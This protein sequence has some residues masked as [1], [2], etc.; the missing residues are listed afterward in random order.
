MNTLRIDKIL[1]P[2]TITPLLMLLTLTGCTLLTPGGTVPPATTTPMTDTPALPA[3]EIPAGGGDQTAERI[4]FE[5]STNE[6]TVSGT[7]TAGSEMNYALAASTGQ[8]V[9]VAVVGDAAPVNFTVYGPGGTSWSGE[10]QSDTDN[11]VKAQ[12]AASE[13]G[14]YLVTL[15]APADG[16]ETGYEATFT[17]DSNAVMRIMF[18]SGEGVTERSGALPAGAASQQFLLAGN[19]GWTI[20]VDAASDAAPLSMTIDAPSGTQWIPEMQPSDNGYTIGQ[21][22]TLTEPGYYLVTL[23]KADQTPS[24]T[25]TVT[26]TLDYGS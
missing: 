16:S 1:N 21:Q 18:P 6:A 2:R 17:V 5:P 11:R 8:S 10:A 3:G 24:V 15:T 23:N 7:L 25:Y 9:T 22:F 12:F 19:T 13:T 20:T 14:D 26:F 4:E